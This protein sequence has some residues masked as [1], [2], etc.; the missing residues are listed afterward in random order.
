MSSLRSR[1]SVIAYTIANTFTRAVLRSFAR[2]TVSG[3][4]HLPPDGPLILVANHVHLLD[5]PLV[6]ASMPRRVRPMAK[7]ELFEIPLIG[8]FFWAYGAFP[9]RRFSGDMGALRVARNYLRNGDVVLMFP[10]GTRSRTGAMRPA[11]PGAG[12]VALLAQSPIV[13]VAIT[14][15][16]VEVPRVFFQ[17]L[18]RDRPEITVTFGE[19]FDLK[20]LN[21]P[22]AD[23][24]SRRASDARAAEAATDRMMRAV[25]ALLPPEMQGAYGPAT[26]GAIVVARPSRSRGDE[27]DAASD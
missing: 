18:R 12:M 26:E 19:P 15:S 1:L 6:G 5:P 27:D 11:L 2:W 24:N 3:R 20:D 8:W 10:E 22:A 23:G 9:V 7:R 13:P 25:A 16:D 21:A 17:W 4:E 14:G